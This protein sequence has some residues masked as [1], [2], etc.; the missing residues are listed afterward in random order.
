MESKT[1]I[2]DKHKYETDQGAEV[3]PLHIAIEL[4]CKLHERER[5]TGE[6]NAKCLRLDYKIAKAH[7]EIRRIKY[8][9]NSASDMLAARE[10]L[11]EQQRAEIERLKQL[12]SC[13]LDIIGGELNK[14]L[15]EARA[16]IEALKRVNVAL[17]EEIKIQRAYVAGRDNTIERKE[18]LIE[19]MREALQMVRATSKSF[20]PGLTWQAVI[21]ALKSAERSES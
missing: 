20:L 6:A 16:E 9:E 14:Q 19:Q 15:V 13:N 2:C 21:A 1:P 4:E 8:C 5:E 11:I 10:V 7:A 18:R 12:W 17:N 3:V